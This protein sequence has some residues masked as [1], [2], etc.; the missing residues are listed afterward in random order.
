MQKVK[1]TDITLRENSIKKDATLGFKEK[2][3]IAKKLDKLNIDVIE[4]SKIEN[5]KT[6]I[7]FLHTISPLVTNSILSCPVDFTEESV[8][9]TFNAI[10][11]AKKK[12]LHLMVP[13]SSVQMEYMCHKKPA[14]IIEMVE[15]LITKCKS[16]CD[17]VEF[18]ALDATRSEKEF[19]YKVIETAI[20]AGAKTVT[21]CDT[22]GEMLPDEFKSFIKDISENVKGVENV[23]LS[24]ECSNK[25]D[26]ATSCIISSIDAGV[27][28]IKTTI[29]RGNV[30]SVKSVVDVIKAKGDFMGVSTDVKF[31]ELDRTVSRL[32]MMVDDKKSPISSEE[33]IAEKSS[34]VIFSKGDDI[35]TVNAI[36][37]KLGYELSD[38]DLT[39][40]Y[41]EF[42]KLS[43]K[44]EIGVKEIEAIIASTALQVTPTFKLKSFVINSGNVIKSTANIIL[45][46]GDE[47]LQGVAIGDGPIDAAFVAI[48]QITGRHFELDDFQ[49]QS[50]TE[51]RDSVGSAIVKLRSAG[52]L[53]SG[54]GISTDIVGASINAYINAMN[55]IYFEEA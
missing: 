1:I 29:S 22:A 51:G 37:T 13:V 15:K 3:E 23:A 53:Y 30:P 28:Q 42:V 50:V 26:M 2:V 20:S 8:E 39:K 36:I 46:K 25:L 34:G 45:V 27:T 14:M 12:R 52:K 35:K 18:S 32:I 38:E 21:I 41:D 47:E 40:V 6:D 17:D 9:E 10:K 16:L 5:K 4:T 43:E 31:T 19:L 49:I 33:E 48:E 11:E 44:K 7:L 24:V 55:K 54:K